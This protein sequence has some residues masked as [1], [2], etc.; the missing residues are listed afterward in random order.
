MRIAICDD[1]EQIRADIAQKV[2]HIY[3]KEE[4]IAYPS[5]GELLS[6]KQI[7]DILFLDI[8][9]PEIDGM[10]T[11]RQLRRANRKTIL[12]FVTGIEDYVFQAFDVMA[13]HYLVKPFSEEKLQEV[14]KNAVEQYQSINKKPEHTKTRELLIK[15]GSTH[16][17]VNMEEIVYAEVFNR[18]VIIHTT[19]EDIEYYGKLS[20]LEEQAGEDFFRTHRAYLIHYK[21]VDKYEATAVYLEKGMAIMAKQ[22]YPKFVK[23]Y[24]K[25]NQRKGRES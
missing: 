3:P 15:A 18:K 19:R 10:E 16:I 6:D 11:A 17:K 12:I 14:L 5:G 21:Y 13:F 22:N 7:P 8:Q 1:E 2:R 23:H 24:L 20:E 25:Y 4:V 9:M